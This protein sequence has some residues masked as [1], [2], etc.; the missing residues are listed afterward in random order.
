M[1]N[2]PAPTGADRREVHI[3]DYW[4]ILWRGR[5]T[6]AAIF[7]VVTTLVAIGTFTQKPI[8]RGQAS[9]EIQ[10]NSRKVA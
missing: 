1:I 4:R 10:L 3:L 8:Y 6:I 5:W 2:S 9:V 7:V